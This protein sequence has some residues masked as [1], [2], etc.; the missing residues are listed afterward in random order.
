MTDTA[1]SSLTRKIG[2]RCHAMVKRAFGVRWLNGNSSLDEGWEVAYAKE[3]AEH[4]LRHFSFT[5]IGALCAKKDLQLDEADFRN[6]WSADTE[7]RDYERWFAKRLEEKKKEWLDCQIRDMLKAYM[8]TGGREKFGKTAQEHFFFSLRSQIREWKEGVSCETTLTKDRARLIEEAVEY[9]ESVRE[10]SPWLFWN[11]PQK[12][13][14][15]P[16]DYLE[17]LLRAYA[18][19]GGLEGFQAA[20]RIRKKVFD[21]EA[22]A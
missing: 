10:T 6:E 21:G 22:R 15:A 5:D 8:S 19:N 7:A 2:G 4:L 11:I 12:R 18:K 20:K 17:V 14:L 13:D 3:L 16:E 1:H 9:L